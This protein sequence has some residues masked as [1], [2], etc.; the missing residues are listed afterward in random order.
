MGGAGGNLTRAQC[1][2]KLLLSVI[3]QAPLLSEVTEIST[4]PL[5]SFSEDVSYVFIRV[6]F[7]C[8]SLHIFPGTPSLLTKFSTFAY[9]KTTHL[10]K[11]LC[12]DKCIGSCIHH[13]G[14]IQNTS[15]ALKILCASPGHPLLSALGP[16]LFVL[17]LW[18]CL[19]WNV[20]ELESYR[21]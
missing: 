10:H 11:A 4:F 2:T 5:T 1:Y 7:F 20:I 21:T 18:F 14:L 3:S 13:S 15:A 8:P 6:R 9:I 16:C 17:S 12:C 19:F